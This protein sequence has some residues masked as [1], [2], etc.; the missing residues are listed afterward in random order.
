M[1]IFEIMVKKK[2]KVFFINK[3]HGMLFFKNYDMMIFMMFYD[4][5][6]DNEFL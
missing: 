3:L 1:G 5:N 6:H 4:M 2:K